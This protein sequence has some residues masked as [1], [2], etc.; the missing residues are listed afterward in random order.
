[1]S[2]RGWSVVNGQRQT[3]TPFITE[4]HDSCVLYLIAYTVHKKNIN[5]PTAVIS[6]ISAD[7]FHAVV[8]F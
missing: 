8:A 7:T 4:Q 6:F 2:V 3:S 1:M 5:N